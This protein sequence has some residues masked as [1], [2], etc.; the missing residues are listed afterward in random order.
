MSQCDSD[1]MMLLFV[2]T[3]VRNVMDCGIKFLT[4][5]VISL[6][7]NCNSTYT[8]ICKKDM[9]YQLTVLKVV[10]TDTIKL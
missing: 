5:P 3:Q 2:S 1:I 9:I 4:I 10:N 6:I 7:Y 8:R